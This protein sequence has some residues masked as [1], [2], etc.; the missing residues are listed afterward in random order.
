M[1]SIR[2]IRLNYFAL[3]L[4]LIAFAAGVY[5]SFFQGRNFVKSAA[6]II[7]IEESAGSTAEDRSQPP[8]SL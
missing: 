1:K 7:S 3:V 2:G 8:Y 6:K 5:M 4:G